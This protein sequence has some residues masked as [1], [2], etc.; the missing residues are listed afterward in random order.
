MATPVK[1]AYAPK[2][3]PASAKNPA[4]KNPQVDL[5]APNP[6]PTLYG[7]RDHAKSTWPCSRSCSQDLQPFGLISTVQPCAVCRDRFSSHSTATGTRE[8]T[9]CPARSC[10]I[11]RSKLCSLPLDTR[12]SSKCAR[13]SHFGNDSILLPSF[14]FSVGDVSQAVNPSAVDTR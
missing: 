12:F 8:L 4:P 13:I 10:F 9:R 5:A 14:A 1:R 2:W 11:L 7:P 6:V 3:D